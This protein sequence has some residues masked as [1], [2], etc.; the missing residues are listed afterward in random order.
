MQ[1]LSNGKR[2]ETPESHSP[3]SSNNELQLYHTDSYC[4]KVHFLPFSGAVFGAIFPAAAFFPSTCT[5]ET[6]VPVEEAGWSFGWAQL[7]CIS[8]WLVSLH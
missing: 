6:S 4:K 8:A 1:A 3:L 7:D 5:E 2:P